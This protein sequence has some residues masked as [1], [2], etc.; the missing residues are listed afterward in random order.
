MT[1]IRASWNSGSVEAISRSMPKAMRA[2]SS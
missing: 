1:R 2:Y